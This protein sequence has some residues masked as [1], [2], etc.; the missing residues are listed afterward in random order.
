MQVFLGLDKVTTSQPAVTTVGTFDGIHL[1][2]REIFKR[3][4]A[5][6]E[7][8]N[9]ASTL[10]T[11]EPHPKTVV[12]PTR[13]TLLTTLDEKLHI[14]Q[15]IGLQRVVVVKFTRAFSETSHTDFVQEVLLKQLTTRSLIVGHDHQFGNHREGT[16]SELQRLSAINGFSLERVEP[17]KLGGEIINST[18]IRDYLGQGNVTAAGKMLGRDYSLQGIVVKGDGRG[19]QMNFPTANLKLPGPNKMM[20][21]VGV[22]VVDCLVCGNWHRGMCNIGTNPTF[23]GMAQNVEVNIFDFD[24]DVYGENIKIK[25]LKRLRDEQKFA[26]KEDLITQLYKDKKASQQ[27]KI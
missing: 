21:K 25:F 1:G 12:R 4:L 15:E 2:H 18:R 20:P 13:I 24:K 7:K 5:K 23:G 11:F 10:V 27:F 6:A 22:Y 8:Q 3:L 16:F 17:F 26:S 9:L 19:R 14:L